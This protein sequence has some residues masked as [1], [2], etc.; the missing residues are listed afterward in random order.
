MTKGSIV[1]TFSMASR[2]VPAYRSII[3]S[4]DLQTTLK[5]NTTSNSSCR[6]RCADLSLSSK[7]SSLFTTTKEKPTSANAS[8]G[9]ARS[10]SPRKSKERP[11]LNRGLLP[12]SVLQ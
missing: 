11:M 1:E 4:D 2:L 6:F 9:A 7:T 5:E 8:S 12:T 10:Q 3:D